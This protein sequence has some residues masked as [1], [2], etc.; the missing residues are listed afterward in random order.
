MEGGRRRRRR[1]RRG[2]RIRHGR[3]DRRRIEKAATWAVAQRCLR[4]LH[5]DVLRGGIHRLSVRNEL[6][7]LL[8][9]M[10]GGRIAVR[11]RCGCGLNQMSAVVQKVRSE[12]TLVGRIR[13]HHAG[14]LRPGMLL[15]Q[16]LRQCIRGGDE[17]LRMHRW[18]GVKLGLRS[19]LA[20]GWLWRRERH[21]CGSLV[22]HLACVR[23]L[24]CPQLLRMQEYSLFLDSSRCFQCVSR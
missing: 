21:R 15:C 1:Q 19:K 7:C 24:Q 18:T 3:I 14:V 23:R 6:R 16:L 8:W 11:C 4:R 2:S 22:S 20:I 13:I 5:N 17:L 12:H 10:H 9:V